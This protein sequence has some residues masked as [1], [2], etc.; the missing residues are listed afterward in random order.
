MFVTCLHPSNPSLLEGS[1][2]QVNTIN[3][4]QSSPKA[5]LGKEPGEG[6]AEVPM[7]MCVV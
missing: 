4:N 5:G 2:S 3:C 1:I 6:H 7:H